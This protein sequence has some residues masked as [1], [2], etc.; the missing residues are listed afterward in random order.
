ML[1]KE[2]TWTLVL[3]ATGGIYLQLFFKRKKE[4]ETN[5]KSKRLTRTIFQD[6]KF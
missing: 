6:A 2:L 1:L 3:L 5:E 4:H